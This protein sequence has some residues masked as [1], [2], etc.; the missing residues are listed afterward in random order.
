MKI[1]PQKYEELNLGKFDKQLMALLKNI[2]REEDVLYLL[3]CNP[4]KT[5]DGVVHILINKKGIVLFNVKSDIVDVAQLM[6]SLF[7]RIAAT[8]DEDEILSTRLSKQRSLV[9][10]GKIRF[11]FITLTFYPEAEKPN[12]NMFAGMEAF[13]GFVEERCLFKDF[14]KTLQKN[15][16]YLDDFCFGSNASETVKEEM[17][18]D[19]INRVAPEYTIP[20]IKAAV[21]ENQTPSKK[22]K[23]INDAD[24]DISE[25]A[26]VAYMLDEMQINY[27]N[28][29]KKGD[30]LIVAC[31][32]SGKSVI[33]IS[34]CFKVAGLNPDKHFLITGYNRN[35]V[36]YF[37]WL[38]DSA[39]FS[40]N[41]VE[42]LTFDKLCVK[43]LQDNGIKVPSTF[44]GDYSKVR[45][46]LIQ[47]IRAG[48]I[49]NRYFG[50]FIDEVQMFEPEWYKACY[51]LVE[52]K[53]TDEHFFVICGDKSQSV[54]KSIKSG[55]APWQG[56]GENYPNFRGKSFP[57]EINYRNSV[58]INNYIKRF[59]DYA[60]R[61]AEMM[62]IPINQDADIFLRGKSI[63]DGL[64]LQ[65]VEVNQQFNDS[66]AEA[67]TI[68][69]QIIDIH[70]KYHIPY[71]SIAVICYNRQYKYVKNRAEKHYTPI[72]YLKNY[73][74]MA[75]IP[76]SLLNSTGNEYSVSYSNIEGVP[77]V[78]MESS[79]GLDFKAAIICGLFP[80]GLHDRT[81]KLDKSNNIAISEE[82]INAYNK[83]IN[84]LYMSCA[85]AK[86]VLRI[87]SAE[88][89]EDSIYIKLLKGALTEED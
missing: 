22:V 27:I 61:Y 21:N 51:E 20:Q 63:R 80:L 36:S 72:E 30:Q 55:K 77:I 69:K 43:L 37:R 31:A 49:K 9:I 89:E 50:V 38:I 41:N 28:K 29:I 17:I 24:L 53:N 3:C 65:F 6:P 79:L 12:M 48:R 58:Q 42:C 7:A 35:L 83:N 2:Y 75:N 67:I 4:T 13:V 85:R 52:N 76:Y 23:Y 44:G 32:G 60:L 11:P 62:N 39:G 86:D 71:D 16:G 40:T 33:L 64:D 18:S 57:I 74:N 87:V 15:K 45:D 25:R 10:N 14:W 46:V 66:D 54:K 34:K 26:S 47:S 73:L 56:H 81:K 19:I 68:L 8:K 84:I 88:T 78:T 1:L 70:E 82:I 5:Q 59:T